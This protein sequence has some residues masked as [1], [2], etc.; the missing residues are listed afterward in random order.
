MRIVD[1]K[2]GL[3]R[4]VIPDEKGLLGGFGEVTMLK[5]PTCSESVLLNHHLGGLDDGDDGVAL[6]E[7]E[8]IG[9]TAGDGAL[10]QVVAH[11]NH[12][13]GHDVPQLNF[14]DYSAQFVSG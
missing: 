8:L 1:P 10:N 2:E 4:I 5:S 13:M 14:F 12:H 11:S 9:A 6:S 7:L 3:Y